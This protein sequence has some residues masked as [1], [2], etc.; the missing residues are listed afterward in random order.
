MDLKYTSHELKRVP[1][2]A[3]ELPDEA[4]ADDLLQAYFVHVNRGWP[5]VDENEFMARYSSRES[6]NN[7]Q[8]TL[9]NAIFL[10]G[11]HVLTPMRPEMRDLK[12]CFFR[13]A[14][15]L[16]DYRFEQDRFMYVQVALL[17]TWHSDGLE[18][19]VANSWHWVGVA[20]RVALGLGMH[21][22][23][24]KSSLIP[25]HKRAWSRTWWVLFQFDVMVSL[26]YGRP[27]ALWVDPR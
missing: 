16:I 26:A 9:L 17:M 10:V 12:P 5:I 23:T 20:A 14:K 15:T 3:L 22:D 2:D 6:R 1:S 21:R 11:A 4:L 18:D 13:R 24:S 19:I 7:A 27:Q 8:L 25:I